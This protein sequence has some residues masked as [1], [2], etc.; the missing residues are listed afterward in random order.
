MSDLTPTTQMMF[1]VALL[2]AMEAADING[3][4]LDV[5]EFEKMFQ[6]WLV[7]VA[8]DAVTT[9]LERLADNAEGMALWSENHFLPGP[10]TDY[11]IRHERETA[12]MLL[13]EVDDWK[14]GYYPKG[15]EER[16][17]QRYEDSD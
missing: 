17:A 7:G 2:G 14:K 8:T 12:E 13:S 15:F 10:N 4:S 1:E 9:E 6:R 11:S 5:A 3:Q 16:Y